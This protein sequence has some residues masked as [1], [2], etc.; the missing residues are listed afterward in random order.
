M[1]IEQ[2]N[3]SISRKLDLHLQEASQHPCLEDTVLNYPCV[4][5]TILSPSVLLLIQV[6]EEKIASLLDAE[7]KILLPDS[8]GHCPFPQF[9]DKPS[10]FA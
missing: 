4:E 3:A 9:E 5:D 7:A 1:S 6:A 8:L 2:T 10:R